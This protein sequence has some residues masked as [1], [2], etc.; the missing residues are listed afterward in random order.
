MST[1]AS[2]RFAAALAVAGVVV[3][4]CTSAS[5]PAPSVPPLPSLVGALPPL[6]ASQA[7][8]AAPAATGT[9]APSTAESAEPSAVATAIDPCQL[10]T[11]DDAGKLA[12]TTF[13]AGKES[14]TPQHVKECVYG[15]QTKDVFTV[16]LA[17]A[18]SAD[19]AKADE[20][21]VI[22]QLKKTAAE[23]GPNALQTNVIPGFADGTDA[24][25]MQMGPILGISGAALYLLRG[26]T[27]F[28]FSDVTVGGKAPSIED[29]KAKAMDVLNSGTLP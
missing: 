20:S 1:R 19:L 24:V 2:S 21:A 16:T 29:V 7:P 13:G 15:A 6:A 12:G 3:A 18:P 4:A 23:A 9:P 10:I 8:S 27:F 17:I 5:S 22:D 11:A 25:T 14:E 28:G 26:T